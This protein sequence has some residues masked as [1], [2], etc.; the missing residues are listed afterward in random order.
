M[1]RMAKRFMAE[2]RAREVSWRFDLVAIESRAG[3]VPEV[4]LDE[5]AFAAKN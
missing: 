3:C 2:R 4:C 5:N 1:E